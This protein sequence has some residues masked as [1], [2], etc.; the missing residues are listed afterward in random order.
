MQLLSALSD[1]GIPARMYMSCV[2]QPSTADRGHIGRA[3]VESAQLGYLPEFASIA[4]KMRNSIC[5]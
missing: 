4:V 3:T 1:L 2:V 5:T